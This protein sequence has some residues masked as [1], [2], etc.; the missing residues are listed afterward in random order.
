MY[1]TSFPHPSPPLKNQFP[2]ILKD[3][4]CT[5][6]N[7]KKYCISLQLVWKH[8]DIYI[9]W[10]LPSSCQ[11]WLTWEKGWSDR[12]ITQKGEKMIDHVGARQIR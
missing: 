8:V 4:T 10:S 2:F 9:K 6:L 3:P 5:K 7:L 1:V 12:Q 11:A